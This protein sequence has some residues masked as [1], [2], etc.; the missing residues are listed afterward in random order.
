MTTQSRFSE[1]SVCVSSL[2]VVPPASMLLAPAI[3]AQS[4]TITA[5]TPATASTRNALRYLT[6]FLPVVAN[7]CLFVAW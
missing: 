6:K 2:V 1:M 5:A 4:A 7:R 3:P